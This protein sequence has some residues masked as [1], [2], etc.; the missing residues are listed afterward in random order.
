M[1]GSRL[2]ALV[3]VALLVLYLVVVT[4]YAILL[5]G[6]GDAITVAIGIALI[7][8]P[9]VGAWALVSELLFVARGTRLIR[10]LGEEG[11]LPVDDLPRLPSGRIDP[12]AADREFPR[13][14]E[15]VE[16]SPESWRDWVRLSLAYDA[17]GDRGRARWAMRRAIAFQ[18]M[19]TPA[20]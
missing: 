20:E 19:R 12:V 4:Q 13:Y 1:S 17:S 5:L 15:A 9:V 8:L 18:R 7:V 10:R 2:G 6:T 16:A 11:G 3:M 14:K